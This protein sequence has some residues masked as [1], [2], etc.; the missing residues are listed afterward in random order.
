MNS[1]LT[2]IAR[3][4]KQEIAQAKK[5][6]PLDFLIDTPTGAIRNFIDALHANN[7][8][9]IAEIKKASPSKGVVRADFDVSTIARTYACNGA[10]CLSVLTDEHFF[11]GNP[12]FLNIAKTACSLP[13]LR[14]DFIIDPY[15]IYESRALGAD[16]ILLIVA[17][18]DDQQLHDYCQLAHELGMAVLVESHTLEELE[19]A[20]PLPTPLMGINNRSL[21]TFNV[22]L[23]CSID[24][25][26]YIP[27]SKLM[28]CESGIDAHQDIVRLQAHGINT[29]LIGESLMRAAD[30]GQSLQ[31]LIHG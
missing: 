10:S 28:I 1:I 5:N 31:E 13:V 4:K 2:R 6:K 21:H 26:P 27:S 9:I 18:L 8:A 19:R 17:M 11:Q 23:Q 25:Q 3:H 22:D 12:A 29:F 24:L 7:P 30:I 16:C 15:Q 14:K 20:L